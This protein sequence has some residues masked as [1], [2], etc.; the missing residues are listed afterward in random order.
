VARRGPIREEFALEIDAVGDA[1]ILRVSGDIDLATAPGLG[2]QAG[3]LIRNDRC[4]IVVDL[5]EA[6]AIDSTAMGVLLNVCRRATRAG[7]GFSVICPDG[8]LRR[9]LEIARLLDTLHVKPTESEALRCVERA[10]EAGR[11]R[12]DGM[13]SRPAG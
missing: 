8:P 10:R 2:V 6:T 7:L 9:P 13:A 11:A 12:R 5:R 4:D 1:R 3:E